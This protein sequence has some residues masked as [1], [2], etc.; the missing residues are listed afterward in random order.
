MAYTPRYKKLYEEKLKADLQKKYDIKNPLAIP[1]L[2][3]IVINMGVGDAVT[4]RKAVEAAAETVDTAAAAVDSA[5]A[6]ATE[7]AP[8]ADA[9]AAPAKEEVKK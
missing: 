3:K 1:R 7:A 9:A 8:A 4:D 6:T 5:A 2:D